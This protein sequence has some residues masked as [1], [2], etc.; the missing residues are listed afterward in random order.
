MVFLELM[1]YIYI[2]I[3]LYI[4]EVYTLHNKE[5]HK[6][7]FPSKNNSKLLSSVLFSMLKKHLLD[8]VFVCDLLFLTYVILHYFNL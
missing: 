3:N 1:L 6:R 8:V 7:S 2:Y 5:N 4:K